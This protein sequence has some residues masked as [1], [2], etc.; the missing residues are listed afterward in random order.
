MSGPTDL[1]ILRA[2]LDAGKKSLTA[3][4]ERAFKGMLS[5]LEGG[6][7]IR[8]SK[9]QREWAEKKYFHLQLDRAYKDKPPPALK[10]NLKPAAPT[11]FPWEQNKP[12]KPPGKK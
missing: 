4:E 12:L 3:G 7:I 2:L 1:M 10:T 6:K 8:L 11:V 5:D 9:S